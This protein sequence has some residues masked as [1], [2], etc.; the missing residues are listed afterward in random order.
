MYFVKSVSSE[1]FGNTLVTN[2]LIF[3]MILK[4]AISIGSDWL[5]VSRMKLRIKD[6]STLGLCQR[7]EKKDEKFFQN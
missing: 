2:K 1:R 3:P 6:S 5:I 7:G 4:G